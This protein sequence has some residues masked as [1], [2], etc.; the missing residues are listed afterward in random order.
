MQAIGRWQWRRDDGAHCGTIPD[1]CSMSGDGVLNSV[2]ILR[3]HIRPGQHEV[4]SVTRWSAG[5]CRASGTS[6]TPIS[7]AP[8]GRMSSISR[9]A[10][11]R[12]Q[13]CP[14]RYTG[15]AEAP[16]RSPVQIGQNNLS[17]RRPDSVL[18]GSVARDSTESERN[19]PLQYRL[20]DSPPGP[21]T[22]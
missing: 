7:R 8:T 22:R 1:L 4:P 10:D 3:E 12:G 18:R 9:S 15:A 11:R 20:S 19:S 21:G 2:A 14:V 5:P 6:E 13:T 17:A 16:G